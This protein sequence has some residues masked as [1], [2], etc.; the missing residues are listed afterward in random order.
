VNVDVAAATARGIRV[1]NTPGKNAESVADLTLAFLIMLARR[2]RRS[3]E[4]LLGGGRLG[5]STFEGAQFLGHDLGGHVLG[6]VGFGQVGRR[7]AA[8]AAA[9]GLDVLVHDPYLDA[10]PAGVTIVD[11]LAELLR[12][13]DF[14]SLHARATPETENLMDAAAF[15]AMKPGAALVNT[16]RETL[17]DEQALRDALADGHLSGAA[18]DVVRPS[19]DGARNPLLD[20]DGVVVTPHI[21]GATHE[22]LARGG[23]MLAA[24]IERLAAGEQGRNVVNREIAV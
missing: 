13:S 19:A 12:R 16:A 9:F 17:V 4:F 5:E 18:L 14:V 23:E 1:V 11:S 8:R 2:I 15:A 24:E 10:A 3:Q 7:V 20:L 6:L 21:G 22:T